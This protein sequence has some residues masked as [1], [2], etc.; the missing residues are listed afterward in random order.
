[1][2]A[3]AF[4]IDAE[5]CP[6]LLCRLIGHVAQHGSQLDAVSTARQGDAMRAEIR[7]SG[8]A[9]ERAEILAERLR[10]IVPVRSVTLAVI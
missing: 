4:S 9:H 7:I 8:L 6:Q 10:A 5:A 2:S 3:L 1:M